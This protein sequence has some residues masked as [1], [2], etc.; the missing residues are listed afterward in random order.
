[1]TVLDTN[2]LSELLRPTPES[3]VV[4]WLSRLPRSSV[5]TTTITRGEILYGIRV[6]PKGKRRDAL[7]DAAIEIFDIDLADQVLSFDSVAAGEFALISAARRASGRPIAQFDAQIAGIARSRG[8]MLAT[9]NAR[10]FEACGIDV[11]N[12]WTD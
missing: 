10:D 6:L 7:W 4:E 9:R 12:P 1:M 3:R 8:A 11:V 2:V 5:F